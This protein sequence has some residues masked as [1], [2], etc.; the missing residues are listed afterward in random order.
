M[1]EPP[2]TQDATRRAGRGILSLAGAKLYFIVAGYSVQLMLPRLL[3]SPES[4]GFYSTAMNAV[5][6]LNNVTIVATVQTVSKHVSERTGQAAVALRQGLKVQLGLACVF[7][8]FLV[9]GAPALAAFELDPKLA[10]MFRVAAVVLFCYALYAA[11]VGALNGQQQFQRQAALDL[12][13]STLRTVGILGAAALGLGAFGAFAGFASA[14]TCVLAIALMWVGIGQ[15]G[16]G[17]PW[18]D[19]FAFMLPLWVYQLLLNL[20]LQVDLQLL[21]RTVAQL[22]ME[23]GALAPVAAE[24][25]SRYVGFYRAAQTFSFVPY[26]LILS[27]TFV[28][29][30][31]VS[32]ATS[33]GDAEAAR[34]TVRGALRFSLIVLLAIACP[35]AGASAGVMRVAYPDVYLAG[36]GALSVLPLGMACFALFV[37][38]AT[39]VS[40]AGRPRLAAGIAFIAVVLV[41]VCN[42]SFVSLVGI[43]PRTLIAAAT[44]TSVGTTF[45]L[46]A[47][48]L[49]VHRLFGTFVAPA[50]ALRTLLAGGVGYAAARLTPHDTALMALTALIVG[51]LAYLAA[52]FAL[53]ELGREDVDTVLRVVL[54]G[55]K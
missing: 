29:F 23:A 32:Q 15:R 5:S 44:G 4:F 24:T 31:M 3:G 17:V 16:Q 36:A 22:S 39:V 35:I 33:L 51:G 14:A 46:L 42:V 47:I 27:V 13:Y 50:T 41:V 37:I 7:A 40:G 34:Q 53:R 6:I 30:P 43:G 10:P 18:S 1:S 52:L 21:K 9:V 19:W 11:L 8:T 28:V 54:P 38:A 2:Q 45:A 49:A 25:A 12:S 55:R 48:G 26:Q 20:T